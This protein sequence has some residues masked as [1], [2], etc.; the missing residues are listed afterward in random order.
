MLIVNNAIV[1]A[2]YG[3]ATIFFCEFYEGNPGFQCL[4]ESV[5]EPESA[6]FQL[7]LVTNRLARA[8]Q[9]SNRKDGLSAG[10]PSVRRRGCLER[11]AAA[12]IR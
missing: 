1:L 6:P 12:V 8:E 9:A 11:T 2:K 3:I 4:Q 10:L 5:F 7:T